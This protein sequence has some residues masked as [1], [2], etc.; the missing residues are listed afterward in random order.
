MPKSLVTSSTL[1]RHNKNG[2]I[3]FSIF[4]LG[5]TGVEEVK[6]FEAIGWNVGDYAKQMFTSTKEDGYDAKHQLVNG[7]KYEIVLLPTKHISDDLQ[8]TTNDLDLEAW[9]FGYSQPLAG[10]TPRIR[11]VIS[12]EQMKK[13][14]FR[15]ISTPHTPITDDGEVSRV[16]NIILRR[17]GPWIRSY[18]DSPSS[19]WL[20]DGAL[21][22]FSSAS[23]H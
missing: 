7:R 20:P 17:F 4:G 21:A 22:Y 15:Y 5:L 18:R 9:K 23:D 19:L 13:M 11:E 3:I 2:H 10:I 14:E 16:F 12:D 6:W 8:R 1:F